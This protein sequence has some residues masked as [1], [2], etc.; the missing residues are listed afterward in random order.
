[1]HPAV[2]LPA[3]ALLLFGPLSPI[4]AGCIS[5]D[6]AAKRIGDA[7]CVSGRVQ[8]ISEGTNGVTFLNFCTDYRTCPFN[9]V[10]F[11]SDL[12]R[13]GDVRQLAGKEIEIHGQVREYD[14]RPEIILKESRQLRG[15][16]GKL[17][18]IPKQYDAE[19]RGRF[20]AGRYRHPRAKRQAAKQHKSPPPEIAIEEPE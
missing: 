20:S 18:P 12:R 9:V 10:V 1:L 6:E 15:S 3:F 19:R 2:S 11:P 5:V 13:V 16:T 7:V 4:H 14:G 8:Q 17:P